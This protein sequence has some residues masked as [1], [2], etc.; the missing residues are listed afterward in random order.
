MLHFSSSAVEN[1]G[2][3]SIF[4]F[5]EWNELVKLPAHHMCCYVVIA[6]YKFGPWFG[7]QKCSRQTNAL[8][9]LSSCVPELQSR[10]TMSNVVYGHRWKSIFQ[11]SQADICEACKLWYLSALAPYAS[12]VM[13]LLSGF[14][15]IHLE[16]PPAFSSLDSEPLFPQW[17]GDP[18]KLS[19]DPQVALGSTVLHFLG[20]KGSIYIKIL[21]P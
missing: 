6:S 8:L 4:S 18:L 3:Q 9:V 11:K 20:W 5:Y 1:I 13:V 10:T 16:T 14:Q 12:Q 15:V 7:K 21:G 19:C 2:R 17:S